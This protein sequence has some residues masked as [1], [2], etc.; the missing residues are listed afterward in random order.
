MTP[1]RIKT[2][3]NCIP[4]PEATFTDSANGKLAKLWNIHI[5][6]GVTAKLLFNRDRPLPVSRIVGLGNVLG[7]DPK[8]H[9]RCHFG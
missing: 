4:A 8:C 2:E 1:F 5:K 6:K 7:P 3:E 9:L